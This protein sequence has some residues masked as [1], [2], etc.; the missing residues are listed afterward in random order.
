[1][2]DSTLPSLIEASNCVARRAGSQSFQQARAGVGLHDV[3][4][5][6]LQKRAGVCRRVMLI[7]MHLN[8]QVIARVEKFRENRK[9]PLRQ[10]R[11]IA[12]HVPAIFDDHVVQR[13]PCQR[14]A[15]DLRAHPAALA[16]NGAGRKI[17]QLPALADLFIRREWFAEK[18]VELAPAPHFLQELGNE[19][20]WIKRHN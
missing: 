4:G 12:E 10:Q 2:S 16:L 11:N 14:A 6:V 17:V 13:S 7:G 9:L 18:R 15:R 8:R 1:M 19:F 5:F 20:E 3:P